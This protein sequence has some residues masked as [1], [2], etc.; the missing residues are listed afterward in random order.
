MNSAT[1]IISRGD[2]S[3]GIL[4]KIVITVDDVP[5]TRL[6]PRQ[7]VEVPIAVGRHEI[8]ALM[9]WT[10]SPVVGVDVE[11]GDHLGLR[12]ELPWSGLWKMI[13][14]PKST[15]SLVRVPG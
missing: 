12:A 8:V 4:R 3:A 15:L 10:T 1:L 7:T 5:V 14:S 11:A 6:A 9:D 2:D 13:T